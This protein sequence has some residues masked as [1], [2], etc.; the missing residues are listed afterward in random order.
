LDNYT[1]GINKFQHSETW[2]LLAGPQTG[3]GEKQLSISCWEMSTNGKYLLRNKKL[4]TSTGLIL[5]DVA[6]ALQDDPATTTVPY[7]DNVVRQSSC[8]RCRIEIHQGSW[9]EQ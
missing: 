6:D 8:G 4:S 9:D 2:G 3:K 1:F 7:L 5:L